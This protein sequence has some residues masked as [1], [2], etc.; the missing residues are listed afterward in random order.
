MAIKTAHALIVAEFL[1]VRSEC[2]D[3]GLLFIAGDWITRQSKQGGRAVLL[4]D[5][6]MSFQQIWNDQSRWPAQ[7]VELDGV[8]HAKLRRQLTYRVDRNLALY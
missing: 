5:A 8:G 7:R 4:R 2:H 1:R 3:A 6:L